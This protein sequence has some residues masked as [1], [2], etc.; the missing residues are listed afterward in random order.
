MPEYTELEFDF[1]TPSAYRT[2][3]LRETIEM[4]GHYHLAYI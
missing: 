3:L 4:A 1:L 2:W